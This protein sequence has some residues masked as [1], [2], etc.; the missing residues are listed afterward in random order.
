M[1]FSLCMCKRGIR[2]HPFPSMHTFFILF[3]VVCLISCRIRFLHFNYCRTSWIVWTSFLNSVIS[4]V[5]CYRNGS[6]YYLN[7]KLMYIACLFNEEVLKTIIHCEC[8]PVREIDVWLLI[9]CWGNRQSLVIHILGLGL[10]FFLL[11]QNISHI[12]CCVTER[13][14]EA[15]SV[16]EFLCFQVTVS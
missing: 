14:N 10:I 6:N 9:Q 1:I 3:P 11:S 7:I 15:A 2:G 4:S 12:T 5:T 8:F 16:R 13:S